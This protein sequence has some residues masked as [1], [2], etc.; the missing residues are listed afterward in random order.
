MRVLFL[1]HEK[2]TFTIASC[3]PKL[4]DVLFFFGV[5]CID[6]MRALVFDDA[7]APVLELHHKIGVK[8]IS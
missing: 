8:A 5:L 1:C 3:C 7:N 2:E 4:A 6:E